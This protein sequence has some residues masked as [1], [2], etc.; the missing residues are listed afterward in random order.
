MNECK[1]KA[2]RASAGQNLITSVTR[3]WD[4]SNKV[5]QT[6]AHI[7]QPCKPKDLYSSPE[8]LEARTRER[9]Q[10]K[11]QTKS[12]TS[13]SRTE[14]TQVLKTLR[15]EP[16]NECKQK[17]KRASAGQNLI[18]SV[19]PPSI[20]SGTFPTSSTNNGTHPT[21]REANL[22]EP[23]EPDYISNTPIHRFWDL[24]NKVQQTTAHIPQLGKRTELTEANPK[25]PTQVLQDLSQGKTA[26]KRKETRSA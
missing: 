23:T 11:S 26:N 10:T 21:A 5:Q 25:I 2:K 9:V 4:L 19:T 7:P 18:T 3:F 12:Q 14:P 1:Q 13:I 8:D 20:A 16:V 17:A 24:S 22:N 6:T 15:Q